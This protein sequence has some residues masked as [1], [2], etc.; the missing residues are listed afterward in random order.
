MIAVPRRI[1]SCNIEF[2]IKALPSSSTRGAAIV[3]DSAA[4]PGRRGVGRGSFGTADI[5][6]TTG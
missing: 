2:M 3:V 5:H 6:C 4:A 1:T